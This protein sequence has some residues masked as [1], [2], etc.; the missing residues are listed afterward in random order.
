[1]LALDITHRLEAVHF[2]RC[3]RWGQGRASPPGSNLSSNCTGKEM[4]LIQGSR[5]AGREQQKNFS[6]NHT[7]KRSRSHEQ[8]R[9]LGES[10][11]ISMGISS[12]CEKIVSRMLN[13]Q[14]LVHVLNC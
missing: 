14:V 4:D 8:H 3:R 1:M 2:S 11:A 13:F 6:C 12:E 9:E 5:L 7:H 10:P